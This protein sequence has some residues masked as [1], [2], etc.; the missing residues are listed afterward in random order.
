[1]TVKET[2]APE[3]GITIATHRGGTRTASATIAGEAGVTVEAGAEVGAKTAF[4]TA[5]ERGIEIETGIEIA[6]GAGPAAELAPGAGVEVT[7]N[8]T[9]SLNTSLFMSVSSKFAVFQVGSQENAIVSRDI[10]V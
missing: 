10:I 6:A 7:T 3:R 5:T 8:L 2:T 1:M 9:Q 4:E